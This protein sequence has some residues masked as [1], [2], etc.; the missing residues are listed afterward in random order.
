MKKAET[1]TTWK[2][3]ADN[4]PM[5]KH[6]NPIPY[7]ARGSTYGACGI[8]IDGTPEFVESVMSHLK[9]LIDGENHLTRLALSRTVVDGSGIGK[10]L[11]NAADK[12][13]VCYIRLHVRGSEGAM[14]S[15]IFDKHLNGATERF[16][17]ALNLQ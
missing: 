17:G 10:E 16:A 2:A 9:E 13:E 7:K 4:Q 3:M 5:L 6:M 15:A 12:A 8:R 1:L 14:A 11:P